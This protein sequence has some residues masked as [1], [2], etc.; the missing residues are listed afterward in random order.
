MN[1]PL[2]EYLRPKYTFAGAVTSGLLDARSALISHALFFCAYGA[3]LRQ[4]RY[5]QVSA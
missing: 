5:R 3:F 2:G 4:W 1:R